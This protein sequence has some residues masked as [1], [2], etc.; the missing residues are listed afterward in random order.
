MGKE[1]DLNKERTPMRV[2]ELMIGDWINTPKGSMKV[3][4]I[5]QD[6][7]VLCGSSRSP[8]EWKKFT[9]YEI[10]P[11][12]LYWSTLMHNGFHDDST[13]PGFD[14]CYLWD[15]E[16]NMTVQLKSMGDSPYHCTISVEKESTGK[17]TPIIRLNGI[18]YVHQL[19]HLLRLVGIDIFIIR[20]DAY[21]E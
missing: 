13:Q 8:S 6:G 18:D 5:S 2:T 9:E 3:R 4:A 15:E 7:T 17:S 16:H 20:S 10:S 11:A 12:P 1:L 19:Q 14:S 21:R